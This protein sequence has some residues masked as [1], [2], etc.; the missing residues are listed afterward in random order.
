[1]RSLV[2]WA[3]AHLAARQTSFQQIALRHR[4]S[5]LNAIKTS[6]DEGDL[7]SEMCLAVAMVLCSMESISNKEG[8][9]YQHLIGGAA[10][11]GLPAQVDSNETT[12]DSRE[13]PLASETIVRLTAVEGGWLL[14]NFA[15]HDVL[16]SITLDRAPLLSGNYW[17]ELHTG[18]SRKAD[19]YFGLASDIIYLTSRVSELNAD[20]AAY[21]NGNPPPLR[22][23]AFINSSGHEILFHR[24]LQA[25]STSNILPDAW[26]IESE[27][28]AWS[29][30]PDQ[31]QK[32][33]QLLAESYRSAALLH[34]YRTL[35][36][37]DKIP[38]DEVAT[39]ISHQVSTICDLVTEMPEGCLAECTLLFPL[40]MA[41]GEAEKP[42]H[43]QT[44]REKLV[45]INQ[46]RHFR[47]VDHALET[48]DEL[49][50][51]RATDTFGPEGEK[52]DW[53][54]ITKANGTLLSIS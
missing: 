34:L 27:L 36:R 26:N 50:R 22:T 9:W 35:R 40:F 13:L 29:C 2:A 15:Y 48:L 53:L 19:P 51:L 25:T 6:L 28:L 54:D 47:N 45:V 17:E 30:K 3:A 38:A 23:V 43:V 1:M 32:S 33:L 7:S 21:S 8:L 12:I 42:Q 4:G 20:L 24:C 31:G 41:G 16:M 49:W 11:L 10:A 44:I 39:K 14:R 52:L 5:A 18:E 37:Y 46:W